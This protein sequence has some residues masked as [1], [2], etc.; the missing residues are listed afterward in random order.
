[1]LDAVIDLLD[2]RNIDTSDLRD[3]RA[4]IINSGLIVHG[5]LQAGAV[6]VGTEAKASAGVISKAKAEKAA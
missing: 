2:A 4:S 6:A 3:Q 1:M 5:G